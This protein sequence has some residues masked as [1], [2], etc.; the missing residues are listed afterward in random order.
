MKRGLLIVIFYLVASTWSWAQPQFMQ[1]RYENG[2]VSSEGYLKDGKPD[3]YWKTYHPNG[4]LKSEGN[5]K[6]SEGKL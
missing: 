2:T 4:K 1:Y 3:G 5:R 6:G